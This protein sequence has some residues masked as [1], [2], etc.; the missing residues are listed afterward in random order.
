MRRVWKWLH[1][2]GCPMRGRVVGL[3]A[4][5]I[6]SGEA[7]ADESSPP[8]ALMVQGFEAA[9]ADPKAE[10]AAPIGVTEGEPLWLQTV[11]RQLL[12]LRSLRYSLCLAPS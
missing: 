7:I 1:E 9:L 12:Q 6:A 2:S 8:P 3:L 11:S 10:V 5:F 4:L